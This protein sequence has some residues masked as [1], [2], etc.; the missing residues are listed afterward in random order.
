MLLKCFVRKFKMKK[1]YSIACIRSDHEGEFENHKFEIFC[2]NLGIVHQFS[3]PKTPQ[4]NGVVE[5][6][7]KSIQEM[8]RTIE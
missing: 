8:A 7:D 3:S 4:Q 2:N 5:R 1:G 6:K